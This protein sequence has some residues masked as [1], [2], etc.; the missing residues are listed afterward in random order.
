MFIVYII[1]VRSLFLDYLKKVWKITLISE[2]SLFFYYLLILV[3]N[4][5]KFDLSII[6]DIFYTWVNL[7]KFLE[8]YILIKK[9][10][11]IKGDD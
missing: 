9:I 2:I 4:L 6:D 7:I 5:I 10:T 8:I 1:Y 11:L 3:L